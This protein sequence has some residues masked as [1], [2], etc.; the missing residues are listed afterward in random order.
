MISSNTSRLGRARA[1]VKSQL[2]DLGS[3]PRTRK[4]DGRLQSVSKA[5]VSKVSVGTANGSSSGSCAVR[6]QASPW[7]TFRP[8]SSIFQA[9]ATMWP[10]VVRTSSSKTSLPSGGGDVRT[11]SGYISSGSREP[12][13]QVD[14]CSLPKHNPVWHTVFFRSSAIRRAKAAG[15]LSSAFEAIVLLEGI[16]SKATFPSP[17]EAFIFA[18]AQCANQ[19]MARPPL[20]G[21]T[22]VLIPPTLT[23]AYCLAPTGK[24]FTIFTMKVASWS[25]G[26]IFPTGVVRYCA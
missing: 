16:G 8:A 17:N 21:V 7:V 9:H 15:R 4:G 2:R 18:T 5:S 26:R 24:P 25:C 11:S 19:S 23:Q 1:C 12:P 14:G 13:S 3:K 22:L 10:P 20:V 6:P